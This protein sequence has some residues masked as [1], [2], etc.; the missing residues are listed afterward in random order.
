VTTEVT[1]DIP[2]R[3]DAQQFAVTVGDGQPPHLR[4]L[5]EALCRR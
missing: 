5:H 4:E 1:G 3:E 2:E